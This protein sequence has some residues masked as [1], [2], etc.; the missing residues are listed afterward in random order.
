VLLWLLFAAFFFAVD[1]LAI[2]VALALTTVAATALTTRAA[3]R[4]LAIGGFLLV[5]QQLF[6][7]QLLFG[8]LGSLLGRFFCGTWL[9]LFAWW[10]RGVLHVGTFFARGALFT[11]ARS[12]RG[13]SSRA[14]HVVR[15]LHAVHALRVAHASRV[16][17]FARLALFAFGWRGG[18]QRLAQFAYALF[19][20]VAAAVFA[21]LAWCTF[22]TRRTLFAWGALFTW[23]TLFARA[24]SS[25]GWRS[26]RGRALGTF[27]TR[28]ALF[29]AAAVAVAALLA[30]VA[31]L[32]VARAALGGRF[33][34]GTPGGE[35]LPCRRT[36]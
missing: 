25:R 16:T 29:V 2:G 27:F 30:T 11:W 36:G 1:Q 7:R 18:V 3:A 32:F 10:A 24:R 5:L 15:A 8:Q 35:A 33:F 17:F 21:W 28:L 14:R 19:A 12:S 31:T 20:T 13:R 22:F 4:A 34:G 9:A 26:S 23:C 6:V